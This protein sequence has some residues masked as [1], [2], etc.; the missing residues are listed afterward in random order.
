MQK[1]TFT[2]TETVELGDASLDTV[3]RMVLHI[4]DG[5]SWSGSVVVQGRLRGSE[6]TFRTLGLYDLEELAEIAAAA[7]ASITAAG[8]YMVDCSGMEVQIV[9]T[10]SGG[11][12]IIAWE[13]IRG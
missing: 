4:Q 8:I 11:S 3:G 1:R 7:P 9:V 12:V 10:V 2:A 5:G 13:P 6:L